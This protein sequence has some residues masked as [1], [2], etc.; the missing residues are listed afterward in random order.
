MNRKLLLPWLAALA[1]IAAGCSGGAAENSPS[2]EAT[3]KDQAGGSAQKPDEPASASPGT[4]P[5]TPVSSD[6]TSQA[7][8]AEPKINGTS[9]NLGAEPAGTEPPS[10]GESE[11]PAAAGSIE[12]KWYGA[13]S[14][15]EGSQM[16]QNAQQMAVV[17]QS[18][19]NTLELQKGGK[20]KMELTGVAAEGDYT[21]K[22]NTL[23]LQTRKVM[24][25]SID[26]AA[27]AG[28]AAF[29]AQFKE[30]M[31]GAMRGSALFFPGK[32]ERPDEMDIT[33]VRNAPPGVEVGKRSVTAAESKVVG[34][35]LYDGDY[36][37]PT[38]GMTEAQK[39]G[40]AMMRQMMGN[41]RLNLREDNTFIMTMMIQFRGSW[42][43]EGDTIQLKPKEPKAI[44][45][46]MP[47][48][49]KP[50]IKARLTGG[51]KKLLLLHE[52][53]GEITG[54]LKRG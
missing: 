9:P 10:S 41:F 16:S 11:K 35:W 8:S 34:S 1:L 25:R 37:P 3:P 42:K 4:D 23:T 52:K 32:K 15:T 14:P 12:G 36:Q 31:V 22:G 30:P 43:I 54:A 39:K 45:D 46:A 33:F 29:V 21:L 53:T 2:S 18:M 5:D 26:E 44:L 17:A 50:Q 24:G 47:E 51:G 7:T 27:K 19:I 6:G 20:F 40:Q 13:L 48:G 28:N 38:A 49:Q